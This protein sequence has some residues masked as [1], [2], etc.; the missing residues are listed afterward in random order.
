MRIEGHSRWIDMVCWSLSADHPISLAGKMSDDGLTLRANI[1]ATST[2]PRRAPIPQ[3]TTPT[4]SIDH[5]YYVQPYEISLQI[6]R[7]MGLTEL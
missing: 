3:A 5:F 6:T 2:P 4:L 7:G 1:R